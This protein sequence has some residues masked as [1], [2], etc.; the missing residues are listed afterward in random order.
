MPTK[1]MASLLKLLKKGVVGAH[2][3]SGNN[4]APVWCLIWINGDIHR[5]LRP[6]FGEGP[7]ALKDYRTKVHCEKSA[8]VRLMDIQWSP[9]IQAL[10]VFAR[11]SRLVIRPGV[12]R[13]VDLRWMVRK[14]ENE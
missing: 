1:D 9:R 3:G 2:V 8:E 14:Q 12:A 4:D 13:G 7:K 5:I 11:N 6:R 10:L